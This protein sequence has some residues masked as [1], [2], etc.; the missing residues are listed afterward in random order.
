MSCAIASGSKVSDAGSS[1]CA[2]RP[3]R[4]D[5][6]LALSDQ[7][8]EHR[9]RV[10]L[11]DESDDVD[12]EEDA[13]TNTFAAIRR[14]TIE[15]GARRPRGLR[16]SKCTGFTNLPVNEALKCEHA[17]QCSGRHEQPTAQ[18]DRG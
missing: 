12:N 7:A 9:P 17:S 11:D 13:T 2:T 4:H 6:A 15:Q 8:M 1:A 18:S 5:N 14:I 3:E 10:L 16:P